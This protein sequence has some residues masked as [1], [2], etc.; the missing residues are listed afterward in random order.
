MNGEH[1]EVQKLHIISI[2]GGNHY[3]YISNS[4]A[5][6]PLGSMKNWVCHDA[7][8]CQFQHLSQRGL[9]MALCNVFLWHWID[10]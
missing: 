7:M 8:V 2:E 9:R 4:S 3:I 10:L 5:P 6:G 1:S